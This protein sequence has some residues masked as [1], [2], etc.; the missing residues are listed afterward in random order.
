MVALIH[1]A[2]HY[3]LH[4][5][6]LMMQ[7][8]ACTDGTNKTKHI[9]SFFKKA[10]AALRRNSSS[11]TFG[12]S[13]VLRKSTNERWTTAMLREEVSSANSKRTES[14]KLLRLQEAP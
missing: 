13:T 9:T 5:I 7:Q 11:R 6:H 12:R 3:V 8:A 1:V 4:V 10:A 14:Q 2:T